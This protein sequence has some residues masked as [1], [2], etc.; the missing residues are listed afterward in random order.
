MSEFN[1]PVCGWVN[2]TNSELLS[3]AEAAEKSAR[4]FGG[5]LA[6]IH[7]DGGHYLDADGS[8]KPFQ[9][10]HQIWVEM[11]SE[12]TTLREA[13]RWIPVSERLPPID[14]PVLVV[15]AAWPKNITAAMRCE[16]AD[17]WLWCQ[18]SGYNATL[19]QPDSYKFDDDYDYTHWMPLPKPPQEQGEIA[20]GDRV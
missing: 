14:T 19:N 12:L 5:I 15:E 6:A 11:Q 13:G 20:G 2:E 18:L 3:R 16:N 10:A 8:D 7:R 1:C 4:L 17:E 9:D